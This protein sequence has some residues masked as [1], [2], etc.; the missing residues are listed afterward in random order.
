MAD[1]LIKDQNAIIFKSSAKTISPLGFQCEIPMDIIPQ[2]RE[3]AGRFKNLHVE[4]SL[5]VHNTVQT[6]KAVVN[7]YALH[8]VSQRAAEMTLRFINLDDVSL[9]QITNYLNPNS[10]VVLQDAIEKR[11]QRA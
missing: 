5:A 8:R 10:V 11:R 2:L 1:V 4:L 7:V 9:Q 3:E 6:V